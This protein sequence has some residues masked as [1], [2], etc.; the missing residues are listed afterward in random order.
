MYD[1]KSDAARVVDAVEAGGVAIVPLDVAYAITGNSEDAMRR[2]FTAKNRSFEK[3]SGM[4]SNGQLFND[5]QICG[6][7]ERAVVNCVINEHGLPMSTVAPFRS[8]HPIFEGVDPF[9]I[10]QAA[11]LDRS[12]AGVGRL[13]DPRTALRTSSTPSAISA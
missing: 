2:I 6:E 9:V 8:D 7:R 5:V 4:L 1:M 13:H 3:P 10:D 11:V 12:D